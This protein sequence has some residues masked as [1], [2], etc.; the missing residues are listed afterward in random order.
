MTILLVEVY[1]AFIAAGAGEEKSKAASEAIAEY[2]SR[3]N[4][5]DRDLLIL[6]TTTGLI[7]AGVASLVAKAFL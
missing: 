3:F 4:K 7:I 2:E 5:V 1:D 6:K